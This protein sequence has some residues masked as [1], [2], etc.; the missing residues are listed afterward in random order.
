MAKLGRPKKPASQRK[1]VQVWTRLTP[2]E[3]G[4]AKA[5]AKACG[6]RLSA[7]IHSAISEKIA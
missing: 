4:A 6:L 1:A 7:W 5:L 2:S 3:A